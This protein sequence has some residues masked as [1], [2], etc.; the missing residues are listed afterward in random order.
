MGRRSNS[1][2]S[3]MK[4]LCDKPPICNT[5]RHRIVVGVA[6]RL[7]AITSR[8]AKLRTST[9]LSAGR[10]TLILT[11]LRQERPQEK[12]PANTSRRNRKRSAAQLSCAPGRRARQPSTTSGTT[13]AADTD[14]RSSRR[15]VEVW[16]L[17]PRRWLSAE[18]PLASTMPS[19]RVTCSLLPNKSGL[20]QHQ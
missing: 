8:S 9:L 19:R 17:S 16:E 13:I 12:R 2:I 3:S 7:Q 11:F 1:R 18:R 6:P 10:T 20:C 14:T 15:E 4:K 5:R